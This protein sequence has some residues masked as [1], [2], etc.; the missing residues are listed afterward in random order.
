V[1]SPPRSPPPD[2]IEVV[3]FG[4]HVSYGQP[5][6]ARYESA[7][8][9]PAEVLPAGPVGGGRQRFVLQQ[10]LASAGP[11]AVACPG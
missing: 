8:F 3:T 2:D 4:P 6:R 1:A 10:S 7:G 5:V 11:A 9:R